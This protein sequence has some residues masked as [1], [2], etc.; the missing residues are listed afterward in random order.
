MI[1]DTSAIVAVLRG[2]PDADLYINALA[3]A[4]Q[5]RIS[6]G[7]Y[8]ETSI[9]ID[10]NHDPVLSGRLDDV[11]IAAQVIVEPFTVR[12]A[13]IAR[14]AYRDFGKGSGHPASLNLGDCFSYAL[15]RATGEP[16]LFKGNDFSHTDVPTAL[17]SAD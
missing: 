10:S 8:L 13:E 2:E 3:Q 4:T 6:A 15:A 14:K 17:D 1:V 7:T 9:V 11:L 12:H 5:V 16:I